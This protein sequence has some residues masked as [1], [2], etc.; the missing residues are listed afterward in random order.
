MAAPSSSTPERRVHVRFPAHALSGLRSARVK[1][2]EPI[3]VIDLSAGGVRFET[4]AT[5]KHEATIVLEF[6]GPTR[7]VLIPSRVVRVQSLR[8]S[9]FIVRS[10]GA[11]V[12]KRPLGLKDLVTGAPAIVTPAADEE[13]RE[14][15]WQPVI[16]RYRDGQLISGFTNDFTPSK[17]Y[18][19]ISPARTTTERRFLELA[20][21]EAI[22][23]LR[24]T[25]DVTAADRA[26]QSTGPYGRRVA[27]VLPSGEQMTG[28]TLNYGRQS[29]GVFVYPF[30]SEF[31][32][33]RVFVTKSGLHNLRLL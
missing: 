31:G 33:A 4:A 29:N 2:G 8:G 20:E 26:R 11:C 22:F 30:D 5:M 24:E 18:V 1:Y 28:S 14:G 13:P 10:Q 32:V 21:L 15:I 19:H 3:S 9:D 23:F 16:G 27:L 17:S 25:D 6:S 7:S 12:F